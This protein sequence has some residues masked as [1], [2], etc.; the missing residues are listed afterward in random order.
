LP[1]SIEQSVGFAGTFHGTFGLITVTQ[2]RSS[3]EKRK[4]VIDAPNIPRREG[5]SIP[6]TRYP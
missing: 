2:L 1:Q 6:F 5:R 3:H 4:Q